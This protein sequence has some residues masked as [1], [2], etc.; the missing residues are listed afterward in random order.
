MSNI[1]EVKDYLVALQNRICAELEQI[2]GKARFASDAWDRPDGGGGESRVLSEG[3]V[4]EQAGVSF[5]HVFGDN[6]PPAATAQRCCGSWP[7]G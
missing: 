1:D 5:S 3:G 2:D 4:F 6:L 7:A